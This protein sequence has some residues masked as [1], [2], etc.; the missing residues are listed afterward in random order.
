MKQLKKCWQKIV[1]NEN[2]HKNINPQIIQLI[3]KDDFVSKNIGAL[4]FNE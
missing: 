2:D 1:S 4:D 3:L